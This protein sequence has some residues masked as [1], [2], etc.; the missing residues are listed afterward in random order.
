MLPTCEEAASRG[1]QMECNGNSGFLS[2]RTYR[3]IVV[4]NLHWFIRDGRTPLPLACLISIRQSRL[5]RGSCQL[6]TWRRWL[7]R[8][9][10]TWWRVR[11][12]AAISAAFHEVRSIIHFAASAIVLAEDLT[13]SSS[14]RQESRRRPLRVRQ[15]RPVGHGPRPHTLRWC[16]GATVATQPAS[17]ISQAISGHPAGDVF[18]A[19]SAAFRR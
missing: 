8:H 18:L 7:H 4:R 2:R 17:G 3:G 12:I 5:P 14:D 6:V 15:H 10:F 13:H 9:T 16:R 11:H 19:G 1:E